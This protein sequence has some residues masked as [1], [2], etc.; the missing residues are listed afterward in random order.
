MNRKEYWN[1]D[2]AEYWKEVT[3]EAEDIDNERT[4]INKLS[5]NDFKTPDMATVID[6]FEMMHY[7]LDETL[8]DYG[9]GLG[10]FYPFLSSKCNYHGI[11]ISDVMIEHCRRQFSQDAD[12]FLVAEGE[13]LPYSDGYF[14]KVI[15]SG[16]FDACY[17]E[18]AL[19][20]ML[21]I[22]KTGGYLLISGK[23]DHYFLNDEEA[24][25]AEINAR[26][27]G[28]PNY[29]TDVAYMVKQVE[30]Y[31]E[32]V[33]EK[34]ALRRGD[35]GKRLFKDSMPDIFYEWVLIIRKTSNRHPEFVKF[36]DAYSKTWK[37]LKDSK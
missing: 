31:A 19:S 8:L 28:H 25:L 9:C 17:Q 33:V 22:T 26:K 12:R 32:V 21:R 36:S 18:Q 34:Y 10:R 11:D 20:E 35:Y 24:L 30:K 23:N 6:F 14:D 3:D 2:Y 15:C 13:N 1:K 29:F 5:G 4:C 27:K 7:G 16:V 37:E